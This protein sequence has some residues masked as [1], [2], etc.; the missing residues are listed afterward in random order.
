MKFI[1]FISSI[2]ITGEKLSGTFASFLPCFVIGKMFLEV[3]IS[4]GG[5]IGKTTNRNGKVLNP[6]VFGSTAV[7]KLSHSLCR[8]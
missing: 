5:L 6:I 3:F 2:K 1:K 8:S 7:F 4:P